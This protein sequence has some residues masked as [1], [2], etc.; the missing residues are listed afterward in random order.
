M[1]RNGKQ[2]LI[3]KRPTKVQTE[4]TEQTRSFKTREVG[5]FGKA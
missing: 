3:H 5:H 4:L 1:T 2:R